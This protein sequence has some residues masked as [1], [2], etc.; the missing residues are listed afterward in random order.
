MGLQPPTGSGCDREV[1]FIADRDY[2]LQTEIA[3]LYNGEFP[4]LDLVR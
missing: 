1:V 3:M 2:G 4:A